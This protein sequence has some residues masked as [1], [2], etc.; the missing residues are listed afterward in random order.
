V[1][2]GCRKEKPEY[3]NRGINKKESICEEMSNGAQRRR[4]GSEG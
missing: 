4:I 3:P 2:D 1:I